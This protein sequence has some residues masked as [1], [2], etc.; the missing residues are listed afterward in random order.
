[1]LEYVSLFLTLWTAGTP[2]PGNL[3]RRPGRRYRLILESAAGKRLGFAWERDRA[4]VWDWVAPWG[5]DVYEG[6]DVSLLFSVRRVWS[7]RPRFE[8]LDADGGLRATFHQG[9]RP[10][11]SVG[12]QLLRPVQ[13]Y[14]YA[15]EPS[16]PAQFLPLHELATVTVRPEGTTLTFADIIQENPFIKMAALAAVLT[17]DS[18]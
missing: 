13:I 6:D 15:I 12:S 2:P 1:M 14:P 10:S 18:G 4:R 16:G 7:W 8:V 9:P 5:F 17:S 3:A 11:T